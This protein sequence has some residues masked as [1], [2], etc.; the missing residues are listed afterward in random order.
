MLAH[1]AVLFDR[2]GRAEAAATVQGACRHHP[3]SVTARN[4]PDVV[5]HLR[6]RLGPDHFEASV[7]TG[8]SMLTA[9]LVAYVLEQLRQASA[10]EPLGAAP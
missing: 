8:A 10:E 9:Q 6:Q 1:V 2:I 5:D 4:L 7:A 3:S